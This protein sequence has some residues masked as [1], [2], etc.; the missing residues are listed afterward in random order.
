MEGLDIVEPG[1][2]AGAAVRNVGP[3]GREIG[4]HVAHQ[5]D[6]HGQELA[7]LGQR[8]LRGRDVV[9]ALR[10]AHE[11]IGAIGGPFDGL[12]QLSRGDRDQRI[13]AIGKQ[14]G[15][16]TAADVG[17]DHPHLFHRH[18]QHHAAQDFAQAM[19]ALAADRQ[20]QMI[21]LGVVFGDRGARLHEVGDDARIDD[22][23]FG[24]RMRFR[25]GG[26]GC[27]LVA[28]RHVEQH[29]AGMVGPDLRRALLHGIDEADHG[30]Q[31]RP[32][33]P[34]SPRS[35]RGPGRWCR[36]PRRRRRRRHG[37]PR[38]LARIG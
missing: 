14:L 10:V 3:E 31:R 23:Y 9:A 33:R 4:A 24:D 18:L 12:A 22:R 20:R 29:V 32:V 13:F 38:P 30:G 36:R 35:R 1:Q 34:R 5:V 15:A 8:H 2:H 19:A 26:I 7:V 27:L 28:D 11:V 6:V 25:K 21:A 16:E 17:T 37:A